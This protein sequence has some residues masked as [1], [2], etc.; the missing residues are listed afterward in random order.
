[1]ACPH[2]AEVAAVVAS[3]SARPQLQP[4]PQRELVASLPLAPR[5]V[6]AAFPWHISCD[7]N[8]RTTSIGTSLAARYGIVT[9]NTNLFSLVRIVHPT[10]EALDID[11]VS[12]LEHR[13]VMLLVRD[14]MYL[15]KT[16]GHLGRHEDGSLGGVSH[17][18]RPK[19]ASGSRQRSPGASGGEAELPR[20]A[21]G[22]LANVRQTQR[23]D[24]LAAVA[25]IENN[26]D[27]LY[28]RGEFI[29]QRDGDGDD[30]AITGIVFI[31]TP[32]C[33]NLEQ[34]R[35]LNVHM[36]DLPIHS[37]CREL[38]HGQLQ[39]RAT[40]ELAQE[41]LDT[42]SELDQAVTELR[43]EKAKQDTL[44]HSILPPDIAQQLAR[45]IRP[46]ARKHTNVSMLFSD[47]VSFTTISSAASPNE[48]MTML[49]TLFSRFDYL[50][51]KHG[52]YKLETIGDAYLVTSGL[53]NAC[54]DHADRLAAFA[55]DMLEAS[56]GVLR[57]DTG[58]PLQ[59]R[60]GLHTG[61]V[62]A[63]VA[64]TTRPRY[65]VFG[66]TVNVASR[67]E[68]T[69]E[70]GRIQVSG[71]FRRELVDAPRFELVLR[72]VIAVKG[73]GEL[74]TFFLDGVRAGG[75]ATR[76]E[77]ADEAQLAL[78]DFGSGS[79]SSTATTASRA[80]MSPRTVEA[81]SQG[82]D[83]GYPTDSP[84]RSPV[85]GRHQSAG[86]QDFAGQH[87]FDLLTSTGLSSR[88]S[89]CD[90]AAKGRRAAAAAA[91]AGG[92]SSS[93]A[94]GLS[95]KARGRARTRGAT[96]ASPMMSFSS[97]PRSVSGASSPPEGLKRGEGKRVSGRHLRAQLTASAHVM[98]RSPALGNSN[99]SSPPTDVEDIAAFE[100]S[101]HGEP[102]E[103]MPG[104]LR[105]FAGSSRSPVASP[106]RGGSAAS[107]AGQR[108]LRSKSDAGAP[109]LDG[110][111]TTAPPLSL[112]ASRTSASSGGS[113]LERTVSNPAVASFD[114]SSVFVRGGSRL[115]S[116]ASNT[117][118]MVGENDFDVMVW[119]AG[120]EPAGEPAVAMAFVDGTLTLA[121]LGEGLPAAG[122]GD[123]PPPLYADAAC[124]RLLTPRLT[125]VAL[126]KAMVRRGVLKEEENVIH[127]W[128][129]ALS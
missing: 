71:E 68:S 76:S 24:S 81:M 108:H 56:K 99:T 80:P 47:I 118:M 8:L 101:F 107:L 29:V 4:A 65:C 124:K 60:I 111:A 119:P 89:S 104:P 33:S 6:N 109:A 75:Y 26:A 22:A 48:I 93:S 125:L 17:P 3:A 103:D 74:Q 53:P 70:T 31:G 82:L 114:E 122:D 5:E 77:P 62:V 92:S 59:M 85:I 51:E 106:R 73:K 128:C 57:P 42:R 66:D 129:K 11:H 54:E 123:R 87:N 61:S 55:V 67:M 126:H 21:P 110:R 14:T 105:N 20:P 100:D 117:N 63:G 91:A 112:N 96:I 46:P 37:N 12:R 44:L 98:A 127:V 39:Q 90:G 97:S 19:S 52:V 23:R 88:S 28:L 58:E 94:A 25:H 120:A 43:L 45:G 121:E 32:S 7:A 15:S 27:H 113:N 41:L 78:E 115:F 10:L 50:C 116:A 2:A 34:M 95:S 79:G 40:V 83:S 30:A 72:G 64:G 18:G 36:D 1:M 49:D 9:P 102:A 35:E 16:G 86:S 38:I 84:H 13:D 69:S